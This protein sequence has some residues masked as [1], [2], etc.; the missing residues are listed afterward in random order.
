[1]SWGASSLHSVLALQ[2]FPFGGRGRH[3]LFFLVSPFGR[4]WD[5]CRTTFCFAFHPLVNVNLLSK[6]ENWSV[7]S[8]VLLVLALYVAM[9]RGK[10]P[11][12]SEVYTAL[13]PR[14][15]MKS[16]LTVSPIL[17]E[18]VLLEGQEKPQANFEGGFWS[19]ATLYLLSKAKLFCELSKT[20]ICP[21]QYFRVLQ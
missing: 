15:L 17:L 2:D 18:S 7:C 21:W 1:M 4:T 3:L 19:H 16:G 14:T 8:A 5:C 10:S 12:F 11:D 6:G 13:P 9:G 20:L